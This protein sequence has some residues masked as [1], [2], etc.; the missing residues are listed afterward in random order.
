M[1]NVIAVLFS[2]VVFLVF[3]GDCFFSI[4]I[5]IFFCKPA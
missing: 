1:N 2:Y 3:L 5:C 4:V